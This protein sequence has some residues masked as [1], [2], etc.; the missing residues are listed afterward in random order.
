MEQLDVQYAI[1]LFIVT[2][3]YVA[4]ILVAYNYSYSST[5]I[6]RAFINKFDA[7]NYSVYYVLFFRFIALL[8]FSVF[9]L[10]IFFLYQKSTKIYNVGLNFNNINYS[11]YWWLLILCPTLILLN[12]LNKDKADNL[13]LY[14][15]IRKKK[16]NIQL[17]LLSALGWVVYLAA[18][19][20]LFRGFLLYNSFYAFGM[21]F[22]IL[23]NVVFYS[24]AHIHKGKKE[25]IG[26]I[27][28]G[29]ILCIL[30]L[31]TGNIL[32]AFIIHLTL[33]LS[34]EWFSLKTH[35][36]ISFVGNQKK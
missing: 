10:I 22:S 16:W 12:Y 35:P 24:L 31:K 21:W 19:E 36:Y 30:T 29:I 20:F 13:K 7:E 23:I 8:L 3:V 9:P 4:I 1:K 32:I 18:Y 5:S 15:Q 17:V 34:N 33:A 25:A 27:P 26:A 2:L 11:Y 14:P 6:K 28:L